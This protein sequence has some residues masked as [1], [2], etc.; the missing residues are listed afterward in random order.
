MATEKKYWKSLEE[1]EGSPVVDS[2]KNN[3][4]TQ[5]LPVE[6]FLGNKENL[7]SSSTSRRDFLKYL[8]FSTAAATIAACE[9]P[10]VKSIP[11]VVKPEEV[12][13][14]VANWYA[15][16]FFN[17]HDFAHVLIK[18]R[19]GRPIKIEGNDLSPTKNNFVNARI[20]ASVLSLYDGQRLQSPLSNGQ[21]AGWN[22]VDAEIRAKLNGL[23]NGGKSIVLL[24]G[25]VIS[26]STLKLIEEFT[27]TFGNVKHVQYDAVSYSGMLD[28]NE[29]SFGMRVLPKYHFDK[30]SVIASFDADFMGN[31]FD[32]SAA[33]LFAE[34]RNPDNKKMSHLVSFESN[35]SLTGSNAD[36]RHRVKPSEQAKILASL[37]NN[38]A[39][40]AGSTKVVSKATSHDE[41]VKAVAD[42]LWA[43]RGK[44]IVVSGSNNKDIQTIVNGINHL[45]GN[46]GSTV[47]FTNAVHL[48]KGSDAAVTRLMSD[49]KAGRVGAL[50]MN[51]VNPAYTLAN[52][53][54]FVDA[55]AK[56]DLTV[57]T[58]VTPDETAVHAKY[59]CPDH[60]MLEAWNDA[61]AVK[62][63]YSISQPVIRPLFQTRQFQDSLLS[64]MGKSDSF[65]DYMKANWAST[66]LPSAGKGWNAVVHDGAVMLE[67]TPATV[68]FAGNVSAAASAAVNASN[69]A[70]SFELSFYQKAG[71]GD[72]QGA[73]NPWLQEL[74]DPITRNTWDNY[75]TI[76]AA[77]AKEL[78]IENSNQMDGSLEGTKVNLT[79]GSRTLEGVPAFIQPGQA[80]GT[81]GLAYGYGRT[82]AG[83]AGDGIG[84]NAFTLTSNFQNEQLDASIEVLSETHE[85]AATQLHHTMMGRAIVKEASLEDF[86]VNG[87]AGNPD[88]LIPTH[89]GKKPPHEVTLWAE[90]DK[91][92]H[93]WNLGID[94]TDCIGCGACVVSC[95]IENNVPVVGRD[96]V[97]KSRD[98]HWIRIDRYYSSDEDVKKANDEDFSFRKMEVPSDEPQVVFMPVMCQHCNHA[99]CETVCPVAATS[100]SSEGLNHMAY[101]RCIGTRYCANNCPYKVRR[102]NWF[103]YAENSEFDFIHM[104]DDLGKMVLNPDVTVRSRGVMEKCSMCI[105][106]IQAGKLEAKKDGRKV[107]DGEIQTACAS[108]CPT[109][110]ITFGDVKDDNSKVAKKQK[111]DRTYYLLE[112]IDTQPSVFYQTKIRNKA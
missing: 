8:G 4:F 16:T 82:N 79:V 93:F 56:V 19:E 68:S 57:S 3:E 88:V 111:E 95:Q 73:N 91:G 51:G 94:L 104:N 62:G 81:V 69:K 54:E 32:T 92:L 22:G 48:R 60:H 74:P 89:E 85:F 41:H 53:A 107:M 98:M 63:C 44:S 33:S 112:E 49:M 34:N 35:L 90:H 75:L 5:Q 23:A 99:P 21:A 72:G 100:H 80:A 86:I 37:Y 18:N 25:T 109:G 103:Q 39:V 55:F 10:V 66:V 12:I 38:I 42:K 17:G 26:P 59:V 2:L 6:G 47:D 110:A 70:G 30:A 7:E 36:K 108:V 84:H 101:N 40:K 71:M 64:W 28:A 83:K 76:S 106:R 29:S 105:Q 77:D 46:V 9:A 78:G 50:I 45:L 58:A 87:K 102:F 24:T 61:E 13:P 1:L 52:G 31:W 11:Y 15:S 96:E 67:N 65:V 97:K 27:S 20:Q 14:G 43:A